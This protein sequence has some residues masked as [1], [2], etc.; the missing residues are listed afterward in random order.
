LE[1][2]FCNRFRL[3]YPKHSAWNLLNQFIWWK[4]AEK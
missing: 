4:L 3:M 2:V 1:V